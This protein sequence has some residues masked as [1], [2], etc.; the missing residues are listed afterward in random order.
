MHPCS[1]LNT[2]AIYFR[3]D[4]CRELV[5]V[6]GRVLEGLLPPTRVRHP[7]PVLFCRTLPQAPKQAP[8]SVIILGTPPPMNSRNLCQRR[9]PRTIS[10]MSLRPRRS[11]MSAK[12]ASSGL[13]ALFQSK[14]I[15]YRPHLA[16]RTKRHHHLC[17]SRR[18][19]AV[20]DARVIVIVV[21]EN[22][23]AVAV[24]MLEIKW[25]L[26]RRRARREAWKRGEALGKGEVV[27]DARVASLAVDE[28]LYLLVDH[29][30]V[31]I[32][33]CLEGF[34]RRLLWGSEAWQLRIW[35]NFD[36]PELLVALGRINECTSGSRRSSSSTC[37]STSWLM[38][39]ALC[40]VLAPYQSSAVPASFSIKM[41]GT[42]TGFPSP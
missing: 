41:Y 26:A 1:D 29:G 18:P 14:K 10:A 15:G 11:N 9:P 30:T 24:V 6:I 16:R 40:V 13:S 12:A 35:A 27:G 20:N 32:L 7:A 28:Y 23:V 31:G 37:M 2:L 4:Q 21:N 25:T 38:M 34:Q 39:C 22:L 3:L 36:V 33:K 42:P 17:L 8:N 5:I 19:L